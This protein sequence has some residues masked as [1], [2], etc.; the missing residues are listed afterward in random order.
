MI[1]F[2][3]KFLLK[4]THIISDY[5]ISF[6]KLVKTTND[7]KKIYS[8]P[9]IKVSVNIPQNIKK[10]DYIYLMKL[11]PSLIVNHTEK[12]LLELSVDEI[13]SIYNVNEYNVE[14]NEMPTDTYNDSYEIEV[15]NRNFKKKRS[16][17]IELKKTKTVSTYETYEDFISDLIQLVELEAD[18]KIKIDEVGA[19]FKQYKN[20]I[21]ANSNNS[22]YIP[23]SINTKSLLITYIRDLATIRSI[24]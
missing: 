2:K 10:E 20:I 5:N 18:I 8:I 21:I 4:I 17:F 23:E 13:K 16:R 3:R 24:I 1:L 9:N 11:N 22:I 7:L 6:T 12:E 19:T 14:Y 15:N